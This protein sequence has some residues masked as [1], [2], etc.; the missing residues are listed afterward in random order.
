MEAPEGRKGERRNNIHKGRDSSQFAVIA[1][2]C[3]LRE[4]LRRRRRRRRRHSNPGSVARTEGQVIRQSIG[5]GRPNVKAG[6]K[7]LEN[8]IPRNY[9]TECPVTSCAIWLRGN[10]TWSKTLIKTV[11]ALRSMPLWSN[12]KNPDCGLNRS[13]STISTRILINKIWSNNSWSQ[14]TIL[15]I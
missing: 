5:S 10:I 15:N 3:P 1:L 14:S 9:G 4:K 13:W 7:P 8:I 12:M 6:V 2:N 11:F